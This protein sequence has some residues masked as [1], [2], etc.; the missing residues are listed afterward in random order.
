MSKK[1]FTVD[2]RAML[3]WGRDSIKDHTT[4]V[5]E[6][7]KNS[8]DAGAK[9]VE[10]SILAASEKLEERVI[11]ISDDG[12]GMSADNLED[13]WL[14]IGFSE[15]LT[16]K[17]AK[18]GRRKTGEKGVGRISA[19]R[20]GSHLVL[21]SQ[22][23][24]SPATGLT[25]NWNKFA[26]GG[27]T[28]SEIPVPFLQNPTFNIVRPS[29]FDRRKKIFRDPPPPQPNSRLRTGTELIIT[30]LRQ[31]WSVNDLNDVRQE[32]ALLTPPF[33]PVIDFQI[34][35]DNDLDP[36]LNGVLISPFYETAEIEA[37]FSFSGNG[38]VTYQIKDR[39][40]KGHVRSAKKIETSWTEFVHAPIRSET[41]IEAEDHNVHP[42][43]GPFD[44]KLLFYPRT[45]ETLRGTDLGLPQLKEF[46]DANVGIKVYRDNIR[47]MPYGSVERPEGDWLGLGDR[48]A[49]NPAG[50]ARKSFRIGPN[51]IVGAVFLTRD[52]NPEVIDTSGREGLVHSDA[53]IELK[54]FLLSGCF[55]TV[56]AKYHEIF[57]S[58]RKED[59]DP[60]P[61][62]T[63][64][65]V[66]EGLTELSK[67]L[68]TVG[69]ELPKRA[70][71][72]IEVL[73]TQ[74]ET[75]R[76]RLRK[77]QKSS[78]ELTSQ[79]TIYRGLA[80]LGITA[81]TFGHETE[82]ALQ[83]C[84]T[85][86]EVA[87]RLL[88]ARSPS[89]L[90]AVEELAKAIEYG[91]RISAWGAFTLKRVKRDKRQKRSQNVTLLVSELVDGLKE[92][93]D[94]SGI[95]IHPHYQA[96]HGE[97]FPMDVESVALNLLTNAYYFAKQ[98]RRQRSVSISLRN[99]T[100]LNEK[101]FELVVGD[102][103][104]G[105]RQQVRNQIWEP[106]FSTKVDDLGRP[107]GTGLGLSIVDSV[108]KDMGGTRSIDSDP[109]LKGARFTVWLKLE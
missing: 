7:V 104:P 76:E 14:R 52:G 26:E 17:K 20:L 47:V 10:V 50:P 38:T 45:E 65:E 103:G 41:A 74:I 95:K 108:V 60:S 18:F 49:Q 62:E 29:R 63:I 54:S 8:Y 39:D 102:S 64:R 36:K 34:R 56:E 13:N 55:P 66:N 81:A 85:S 109:E 23:T 84:L 58:R 37:D 68:N 70:S 99:A 59:S 48:K 12:V 71:G 40:E 91:K 80:T 86:V 61:R 2:A 44:V 98:N 87:Y 19:D 5:L 27:K 6:L 73:R 77:L 30:G 83:S 1:H 33:K 25:V 42:K 22:A 92:V 35:I 11:R 31:K 21:K 9:I 105:V 93:F 100:R 107:F 72:K 101:G 57:M 43:C 32:L 16:H 69:A 96:V 46:L 97:T 90:V 15:K 53:F 24:D 51:Q 89:P 79:A 82:I 28:I 106:L 94:A 78:E 4:A 67:S 3:T 75:S 88:K